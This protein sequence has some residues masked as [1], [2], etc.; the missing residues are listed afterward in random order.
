MSRKKFTTPFGLTT[1]IRTGSIALKEMLIGRCRRQ[2]FI[3]Q[4]AIASL[5][6]LQLLSGNPL[7]SKSGFTLLLS[8]VIFPKI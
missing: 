6:A 5:A 1:I 3:S 7:P 2:G 4:D 8:L